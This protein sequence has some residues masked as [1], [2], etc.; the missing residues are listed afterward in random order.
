MTNN[1]RKIKKSIS[2]FVVWSVSYLILNAL[3][4][5]V[6]MYQTVN[7][8]EASFYLGLEGTFFV[9]LFFLLCYLLPIMIVINRQAKYDSV[10]WLRIV[11]GILLIFLVFTSIIAV[12]VFLG[13]LLLAVLA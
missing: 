3:L 12:I 5:I 8:I 1:N 10:K 7:H 2:L 11:S 13:A 4:I 9:I 6:K